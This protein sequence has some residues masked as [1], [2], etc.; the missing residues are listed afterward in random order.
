MIRNILT[1]SA[2]SL[3]ALLASCS[4]DGRSINYDIRPGNQL[5][6]PMNEEFADLS[7]GQPV[8]FEWAPSMAEDNGYVSYEVLFDRPGG[9]F[10]N[11][12]GRV[13]SQI[14]GSRSYVSLSAKVLSDI[15]RST[16][17]GIY[18]VGS[19][20]WT[21]R[22]SKG[23]GG[24]IYTE[25]RTIS[26]RTMNSM[27]PLPERVFVLG[28][29]LAAEEPEGGIEMT[30]SR[31]IDKQDPEKGSF[32]CFTKIRGGVPFQIKDELGRYYRLNPT[33]SMEYSTEALESTIPDNGIYWIRMDFDGMVWQKDVVVKI[34]YY[35]ASWSEDRMTT[36]R[37]TMT[38]EGNGVWSLL[39]YPNTISVNEA[40][41]TRHRFDATLGDDSMVYLGTEASLGSTYTTDYLKVNFY[42]DETIGSKDWDKTYNFLLSDAGRTFDCY[43]RLNSDND[44]HTW[45][46]EYFFKQ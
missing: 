14:N 34:E 43:L 18:S 46:H 42:T 32:E 5:Y 10:S 30:V 35:A 15:A 3:L 21:V 27:D 40:G 31:G 17:I 26:V 39:N 8:Q 41:D 7:E 22:A 19:L 45:W 38:Y 1:L 16:G 12:A 4:K 9:N 25:S 13:A 20:Q 24:T 36:D 29:G 44:A 2:V 37:R 6:L 33:G 23:I 11:P 28:D